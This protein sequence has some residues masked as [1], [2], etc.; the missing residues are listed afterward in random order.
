MNS[1]YK[2]LAAIIQ[3]RIATVL[4]PKIHKTQY[5]FRKQRGTADAL[6][7]IRRVINIAE[8]QIRRRCPEENPNERMILVLLDWGKST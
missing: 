7:N 4:D 5:G 6:F 1:A 2:L 8:S 3:D